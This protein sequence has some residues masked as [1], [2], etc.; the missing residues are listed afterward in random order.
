MSK[1]VELR[2]AI[3]LINTDFA[4]LQ[5][6]SFQLLRDY[7]PYALTLS[8]GF[9][10]SG[11]CSKPLLLVSVN[12]QATETVQSSEQHWIL[13]ISPKIETDLEPKE[14]KI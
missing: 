14:G 8:A 11:R 3:Q 6:N 4:D 10:G 13:F 5:V 7:I 9:S 12:L 1:Q 2:G